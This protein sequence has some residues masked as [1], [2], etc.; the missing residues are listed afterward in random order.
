MTF[1]RDVALALSVG[2][3]LAVGLYDTSIEEKHWVNKYS[4]IM[5]RYEFRN[6]INDDSPIQLLLIVK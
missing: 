2:D 5:Q 6:K 4:P 1:E 3:Y